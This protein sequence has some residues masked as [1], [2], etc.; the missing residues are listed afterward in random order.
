MRHYEIV[1]LVHPDQ[2][3]QVGAMIERYTSLVTEGNGTVHRL[4]DWGRRQLAY[5]IQKVHK[6]HYVLMNVECSNEILDELTNSFRFNDAVIRN[7]VVRL[8][9]AVTEPSIMKAEEGRNERRE[10]SAK[11]DASDVDSIEAADESTVEE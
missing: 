5:P 10:D 6:A 4:E 2:S 1:F 7:M 9:E 11:K 8:N 3:E